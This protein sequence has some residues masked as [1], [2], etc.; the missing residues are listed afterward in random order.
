MKYI[1]KLLLLTGLVFLENFAASVEEEPIKG[2]VVIVGSNRAAGS[3]IDHIIKIVGQEE[4]DFSHTK[5][6]PGKRVVSI[7]PRPCAL[8]PNC[9]K[10]FCISSKE[11]FK[12]PLSIALS[13]ASSVTDWP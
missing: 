12:F 9:G 10:A 3:L 4:G 8:K 7:D 6:F 2:A 11:A 13:K 1:L 5:S